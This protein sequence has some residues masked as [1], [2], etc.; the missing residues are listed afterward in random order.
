MD[1]T[2]HL[3]IANVKEVAVTLLTISLKNEMTFGPHVK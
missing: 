3:A 1:S 2:Y